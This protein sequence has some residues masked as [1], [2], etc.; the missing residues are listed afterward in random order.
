MSSLPTTWITTSG[1]KLPPAIQKLVIEYSKKTAGRKCVYLAL[2]AKLDILEAEIM[3]NT[4]SQEIMNAAI[5]RFPKNESQA[6]CFAAILA[7]SQKDA[8]SV[9][10]EKAKED[11][12]KLYGELVHITAQ[13]LQSLNFNASVAGQL[14]SPFYQHHMNMFIAQF[15]I[16]I[17]QDKLS[18]AVKLLK[19]NEKKEKDNEPKTLSTREYNKLTKNVQGSKP[20]KVSGS[21]TKPKGKEPSKGKSGNSKP[22][23]TAKGKK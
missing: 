2:K 4:F 20:A 16:K 7:L 15:T 9:K 5:K 6:K 1:E 18:K 14:V 21:K 13:T 17:E 19:L 10:L 11:I 8:I 22:K 3:G 12:N 23:S